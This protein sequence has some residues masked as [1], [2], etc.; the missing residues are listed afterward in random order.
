[1]EPLLETWDINARL[2]LY[3][4]EAIP[5]DQLKIKLEKGKTVLGNFTHVHNVRLMWLKSAA[6]DLLEGMEKLDD[7]ADRAS[8]VVA[9]T[10]SAA[11]IRTL[12]ERAG[13]PDGKVKGFKPHATGFVG[14]M[15]AHEAFHR[16]CAE[17]ALRQAG[18]ALSDKVAYGLWEWG[19]R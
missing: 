13:T 2:N 19:V 15:V 7:T 14:Y 11:A 16:T 6:P 9:L 17:V 5:D 12:I 8:V 18:Q 3:L 10:A 4:L 1:M